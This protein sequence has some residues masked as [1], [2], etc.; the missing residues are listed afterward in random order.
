MKQCSYCG[1]DNEQEVSFCPGCGTAASPTVDIAVEEAAAPPLIEPKGPLLTARR[2]TL[3][4][5]IFLGAQLA[6]AFTV[7]LIAAIAS[8]ILGKGLSNA[9]QPGQLSAL[10]FGSAAVAALIVSGVV[11]FM[12]ALLLIGADLKDTSPVG[13]AWRLGGWK[14]VA[15]G[16]GF[17]LLAGLCYISLAL[18]L[19]GQGHHGTP[20][21]L[22]RLAATPGLPRVLWLIVALL[23]APP[24]E[25][26]LFRGLLYGGYRR[27]FGSTKAAVFTTAIFV[28]LHFTEIIHFL[29]GILG[30]SG[31][32]LLALWLRLRFQAIGPAIAAHFGYNAVL[33]MVLIVSR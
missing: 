1:K 29:P 5:L 15:Q 27:S 3:I 17:G 21:P 26:L 28:V 10:S 30:V 7:G 13:A 18:A 4:F 31:I 12:L 9:A 22:T 8:D 33:A 11:M 2:A 32:A 24:I 23:L 25:E 16:L 14:V 19:G 20:G 6:A